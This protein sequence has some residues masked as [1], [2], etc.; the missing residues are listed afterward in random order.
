[1]ILDQKNYNT[2]VI[3]E[4]QKVPKLLD[5]VQHLMR[6]KPHIQ[7]IL[8]GSS[9]R[10]LKRGSGNLLAGRAFSYYLFPFSLFELGTKTSIH[11]ILEFGSLPEVLNKKTQAR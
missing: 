6:K 9:A 10:K 5:I 4:I 3:D 1:M 11:D 7:F 8:T 2:V